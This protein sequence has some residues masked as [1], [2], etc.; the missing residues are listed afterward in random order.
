MLPVKRPFQRKENL[1]RTGNVLFQCQGSENNVWLR[2]A[3]IP[4]KE[5]EQGKRH[6]T[7]NS[8]LENG[9]ITQTHPLLKTTKFVNKTYPTSIQITTDKFEK[10]PKL[11]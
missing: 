2:F 6:L 3:S 11:P 4:V 9:N 7:K 8:N 5:P 10:M 1:N